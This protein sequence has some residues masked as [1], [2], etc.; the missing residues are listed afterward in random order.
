MKKSIGQ[1]YEI[2]RVQDWHDL[3]RRDIIYFKIDNIPSHRFKAD[4]HA[5]YEE[6]NKEAD[7]YIDYIESIMGTFTIAP[8]Y[9]KLYIIKNSDNIEKYEGDE[10]YDMTY[11]PRRKK[12][13][14]KDN[15]NKQICNLCRIFL[16]CFI[17]IISHSLYLYFI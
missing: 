9:D 14:I 4:N 3:D 16:L 10:Y 13:I 5:N 15:K 17:G 11:L 6:A 1:T 12:R 7:R 2:W 8:Y